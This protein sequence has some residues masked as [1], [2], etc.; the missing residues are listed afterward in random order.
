MVIID[1]RDGSRR[2]ADYECL[3]G[4]CKVDTLEFG[5]VMLTGHGPDPDRAMTIGVEVKSVHDLLSSI[6]SGRLAGHQI[7]GLVKSYDHAW[8]L[9]YGLAR[10]GNDNYL[11]V[12]LHGKWQ[13]FKLGRRP[14]PWSFLEGFLLTAQLF[15]PLRVKWVYNEEQAA[16]WIAVLDRWL[17]KKWDQHKGMKVFNTSGQQAAPVGADPAEELMAKIAAQLPGVGWTR[18]WAAAKHFE[19]VEHMINAAAAEWE[20]IDKFGPVLSKSIRQSIRRTK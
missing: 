14:V 6:E 9:V 2:L 8:L 11:E 5:D 16:K 19:S 7:P 4:H 13:H 10:P 3:D 15:S 18:G 20:E 12:N 17:S 1:R